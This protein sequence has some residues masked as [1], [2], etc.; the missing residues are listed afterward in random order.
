MSSWERSVLALLDDLEQQAEGLHLVE[1]DL[2]VADRV[3]TEY[4]GVTLAGRW[5]ASVGHEVR[6]RLIGGLQVRGVLARVGRDWLLVADGA[7]EWVVPVAA[8]FSA[9]G[10]SA[11]A[12]AEETWSVLDRL[13]MRSVLRGLS[14]SGAE[15]VAHA[16]D[17][18]QVTGRVGRVGSDFVEL[19]VGDGAVHVVP[20]AGLCAL[21]SRG[22][23]S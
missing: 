21:Q 10:L 15:C 4:A 9:A 1:R 2:E 5:H 18:H 8:V 16:P 22:G 13:G 11:R 20:T 19:R 23:A 12:E 17:G 7:A 3:E 14:R 6:L